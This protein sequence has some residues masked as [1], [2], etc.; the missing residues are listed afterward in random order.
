MN[1]VTKVYEQTK[2]LLELLAKLEANEIDRDQTTIEI[3]RLIAE[4]EQL[5][6]ALKEPY[7]DEEMVVGKKIVT[8]N[9]RLEREMGSLFNHIK[10]DMK[11]VKQNKNLNYSYINPLGDMKTTD[12][13]YIDNKL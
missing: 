13:M 5:I 9:I 6:H 11:K 12:G 4:R 1:R 7:T 3:D 10:K 2:K 8:L